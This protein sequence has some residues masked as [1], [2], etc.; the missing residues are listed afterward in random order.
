MKKLKKVLALFLALCLCLP[1]GVYADGAIKDITPSNESAYF[2]MVMK[3]S[4]E[5]YNYD[6]SKSDVLVNIIRTLLNKNPELLDDALEAFFEGLDD[7][8]EFFT[9]EE[10]AEFINY[11][12]NITGAIGAYLVKDGQ[13]ITVSEVVK[14]G[15]AYEAGVIAG[16][17]IIR[18][19]D[20]DIAG[21]DMDKSVSLLKGK[22]G[23]TVKI[24]VLRGG[25]VIDFTVTRKELAEPTVKYAMLNDNTVYIAIESF[26]S[27]TYEEFKNA[28]SFAKQNYAEN[29]VLDLR[30]NGGGYIDPAIQIAKLFVPKGTIIEHRMRYGGE[31]EV[32]KSYLRKCDY[33]LV[34][35]VNEYT[36]SASEILASA[37]SESGVS[38]LVGVKTYGKAVTQSVFGLYG[39]R[40]CKLTTGE[41]VTRNGNRINKI[42]IEPD[43]KAE[44]D[45][46]AFED[47]TAPKPIYSNEYKEGDKGEAIYGFKLRLRA[48][49]FDIGALND[50]Y[51]TYLK[52]AVLAYQKGMGL[53]ETGTLN[54]LTDRKSVV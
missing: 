29:I 34:T 4:L 44:N 38:K 24:S 42:G 35:L 18:I 50:E 41:Y 39:G 22:I 17:K 40:Y 30:N 36:A 53:D 6:V 27:D 21:F 43:V 26:A 14:T 2:E 7:Y 33:K 9:P 46:A 11:V 45:I 23:T 54:I 3:Q 20:V 16:D 25:S 15:G 8:S 37:L 1:L 32:Y 31:T 49:G 48:L 51:D 12:E 47:T 19:D 13:Y 10:Y 52:D 28:M 5:L